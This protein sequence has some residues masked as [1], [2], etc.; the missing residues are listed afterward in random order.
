MI[1]I[2]RIGK[3]DIILQAFLQVMRMDL[4]MQYGMDVGQDM[5]PCKTVPVFPTDLWVGG[6][7]EVAFL[8]SRFMDKTQT[9]LELP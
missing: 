9:F 6:M 3:H 5:I 1:R 8:G 4:G 7:A 2:Y